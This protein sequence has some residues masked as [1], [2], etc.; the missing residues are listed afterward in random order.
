MTQPLPPV[1]DCPDRDLWLHEMPVFVN[2]RNHFHG[3]VQL[4]LSFVEN[5]LADSFLM[6]TRHMEILHRRSAWLADRYR[7]LPAA[8]IGDPAALYPNFPDPS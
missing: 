6:T 2:E 8:C 4:L 5:L 3:E 7:G 1:R